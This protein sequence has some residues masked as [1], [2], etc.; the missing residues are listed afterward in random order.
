MNSVKKGDLFEE[1]CYDIIISALEKG[2]LGIV[3]K[4]CKVYKKKKYYSYIRESDIIFDLSIEV[5]PEGASRPVMI[6]VIECKNLNT[7][8]PVDDVEEFSHKINSILGTT[9]KGVFIANG[10][11]QQGAYNTAKNKG[12]MLIEVNENGYDIVLHKKG[13]NNLQYQDSVI[14]KIKE[15]VY[16]EFLVKEVSGLKKL[17][18]ASIQRIADN[19]IKDFFTHFEDGIHYNLSNFQTFLQNYHKI[20][21]A[22]LSNDDDNLGQ[23]LPSDNKILIK[24]IKSEFYEHNFTLY[25]EIAH[26]FLHKSVRINGNLYESFSDAE[27]SHFDNK[28]ILNNPKN[29]IEWQAN[30]LASCLAL[31]KDELTTKI[32]LWQKEKGIRNKGTIYL[33]S[34]NVNIDDFRELSNYLSH[35]F[36]ISKTVIKYRLLD[37][38]ILYID[39]SYYKKFQSNQNEDTDNTEYLRSIS[40]ERARKLYDF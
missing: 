32:I 25:H 5:V 9:I 34:Q 40:I 11:L 24:N 22:F 21:F 31:P 16:E 15:K 12:F 2:E 6:Y 33:D 23:F 27:F 39:S 14:T 30:Y 35:Y 28:Y 29:W 17:S 18:K 10:K 1:K 8:V 37:L 38:K 36:E 20:T 7:N 13:K 26:Y 4:I 3:P 19:I